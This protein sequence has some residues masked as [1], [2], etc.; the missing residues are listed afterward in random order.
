MQTSVAQEGALKAVVALEAYW[1]GHLALEAFVMK[2]VL[3]VCW[4]KGVRTLVQVGPFEVLEV[5]E[6]QG[7]YLEDPQED[8]YA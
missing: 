7:A 4:K 2:V 1:E 6:V 3:A 5:L 8:P